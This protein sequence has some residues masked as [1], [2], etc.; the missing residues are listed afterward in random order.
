[1][2]RFVDLPDALKQIHY[3]GFHVRDMGLLQGCLA[4]PQ[5]TVYGEDAYASL[6]LK[7]AALLH[8]L[9]TAHPMVDGNKRTG[10]ALLLTFLQFNEWEII[11]TPND[12]LAF[13]VGVAEGQHNLEAIAT[14]IAK[15]L[16]PANSE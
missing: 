12:A 8:S 10:W 2:T 9:V 7:A 4:R 14:W 13:I 16:V 5:T 11:A 3:L 6:E 1:M 15:H